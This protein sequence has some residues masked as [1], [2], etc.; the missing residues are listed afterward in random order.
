MKWTCLNVIR[1]PASRVQKELCENISEVEKYL[2]YVVHY[3]SKAHSTI[4]SQASVFKYL[5][6]DVAI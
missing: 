1:Y 5:F 3:N 6:E 4:L 2:N